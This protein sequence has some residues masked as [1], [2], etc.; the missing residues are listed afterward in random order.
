MRGLA[1]QRVALILQPG[2][3]WVIE[4]ALITSDEIAAALRT[5]D[6]RGWVEVA[7]NA[8]PHGKLFPDGSLPKGEL[9][10]SA[11]PV[12]R[13]TDSGWAVINRHYMW[14]LLTGITGIISVLLGFLAG[15][16]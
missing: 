12:Y 15:S 3:V 1:R 6:M 4:K 13:L 9:F 10:S 14:L 16:N 5:C 8:L 7:E 2:N 11:E